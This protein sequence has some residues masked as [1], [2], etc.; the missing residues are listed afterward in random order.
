MKLKK[1]SQAA[2]DFMAKIRAKRKKIS[3]VKE[4]N[5]IKKVAKKLKV[6]L[7]HGYSTTKG[8]VRV[9]GLHKDTKSHNVNVSVISGITTAKTALKKQYE[10]LQGRL[11]SL[12]KAIDKRKVR[13]QITLVKK[14]FN[15]LNKFQ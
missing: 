4:T 14:K 5:K 8:K 1:G 11:L 7:P 2:K 6:T 13:K 9:S 15:Q 12:K 10:N 3:G